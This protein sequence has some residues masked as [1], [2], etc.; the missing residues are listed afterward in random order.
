MLEED[1]A[2]GKVEAPK[3]ATKTTVLDRGEIQ[4]ADGMKWRMAGNLVELAWRTA[5][6]DDNLGFTLEKRPSYGGDFQEVVS[7]KEVASLK[8]RGVG[9]GR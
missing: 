2:S 7:F 3:K 9:G 6:E 4:T 8:S 5:G 1:I